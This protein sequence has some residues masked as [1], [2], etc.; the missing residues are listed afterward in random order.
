MSNDVV[1]DLPSFVLLTQKLIGQMIDCRDSFLPND[2]QEPAAK[3]WA[4]LSR[5]E[6]RL[7]AEVRDLPSVTL[8]T[9]GLTGEQLGFRLATYNR[10][11]GCFREKKDL[12]WLKKLLKI[13]DDILGSLVEVLTMA[14]P[15]K[16][17]KENLESGI[18]ILDSES[19]NPSI[20]ALPEC[21]TI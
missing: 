9:V 12:V 8:A 20:H 18:D 17:M 6:H 3:A 2:L 5:K 14:E 15:L 11:L 16:I 4:E 10:I 21:F 7:V 13:T 1:N 19:P